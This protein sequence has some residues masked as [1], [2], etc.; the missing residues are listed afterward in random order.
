M[1]ERRDALDHLIHAETGRVECH[2][3]RCRAQRTVLAE[4]TLRDERDST[5]RHSPLRP[6]AG[7]VTL[8]TTGMSELDVVARI[9]ALARTASSMS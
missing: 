2:G 9:A 3:T 1:H 7:A 5:R 8:D 4:Q 6:S